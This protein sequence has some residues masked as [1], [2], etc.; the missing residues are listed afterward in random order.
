[1]PNATPRLAECS[2][3]RR[4]R[5]EFASRFPALTRSTV[6]DHGADWCAAQSVEIFPYTYGHPKGY[7]Q[8]RTETP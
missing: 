7:V 6:P 1:M 2:R 5:E 4:A 3:C 8:V